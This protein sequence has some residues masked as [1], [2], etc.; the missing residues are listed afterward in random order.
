MNYGRGNAKKYRA[1][2]SAIRNELYRETDIDAYLAPATVMEIRLTPHL[3]IMIHPRVIA[4]VEI[5]PR[6]LLQELIW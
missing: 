3:H 5:P 2:M 4:L 6:V 1:Q